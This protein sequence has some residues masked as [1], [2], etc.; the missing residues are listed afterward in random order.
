M[1]RPVI[2]SDLSAEAQRAKAEAKRSNTAVVIP[3]WSEGPD[4]ESRD[5]GFDAIESALCADPMASP[6]NDVGDVAC[7]ARSDGKFGIA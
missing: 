7:F 6:R 2:A 5:S 3:G 1:Q 4:P